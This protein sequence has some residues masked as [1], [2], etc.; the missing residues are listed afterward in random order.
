MKKILTALKKFYDPSMIF[1][2]VAISFFSLSN[3]FLSSVGLSIKPMPVLT[4]TALWCVFAGFFLLIFPYK[5]GRV[6]YIASYL[7]FIIYC[8]GQYCY[9]CMF[10]NMFMLSV[11]G[12][13]GEGFT[14]AASALAKTSVEFNLLYAL[15]LII[16]FVVQLFF[17]H[18]KAAPRRRFTLPATAATVFAY[19]MVSIYIPQNFDH[20][21]KGAWNEWKNDY[22]MYRTCG[23]P[24]MVTKLVG[25]QQYTMRYIVVEA[26][27]HWMDHS[28]DAAIAQDFFNSRPAHEANLHTGEFKGKNVIVVLMESIDDWLITEDTMPN[29]YK[30]KENSYWFTNFYTPMFGAAATFNSEYAVNTGY[31]TPIDESNVCTAT[32]NS[33]SKSMAKMFGQAGY[34]A[35]SFH[36]N[37]GS[38]YNRDKIHKAMGFEKYNCFGTYSDK[39]SIK[40]D[41]IIAENEELYNQFSNREKDKPFFNYLITFSAHLPYGS[42]AITKEAYK[43][44]PE[45]ENITDN[46]KI[47]SI[48]AKAALTDDMFGELIARLKEE[49]KL[50]DTVIIGFSDHYAYGLDKELLYEQSGLKYDDENMLSKNCLFIYNSELSGCTVDKVC[51]TADILPTTA[52]LFGLKSNY[53]YI[54]C[55]IFD[56]NYDG[57]AF[58]NDYSWVNSK[59]YYNDGIKYQEQIITEDEIEKINKYVHQ[60]I[61]VNKLV[62]DFDLY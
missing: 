60:A 59:C 45:L 18:I 53:N 27:K 48:R 5:A 39:W 28:K 38:F 36:M 19:V 3:V 29:L 34:T 6:M 4:F 55:D 26:E 16:G 52:N 14:F 58:F 49:G 54:G 41:S 43:R 57:I 35:Q 50:E 46:P 56:K 13:A 9:Y 44:H 62:V 22:D 42:G 33:Y 17:G 21:K 61:N 51:N 11:L 37:S 47:N 10:G 2:L 24:Y 1:L 20:G 7:V 12:V 8:Y 30:M 40:F 15:M 32:G 23:D 25:I 31:Y